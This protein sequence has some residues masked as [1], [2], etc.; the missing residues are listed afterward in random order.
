[1]DNLPE[2]PKAIGNYTTI[3][4]IGYLIYTSGHIPITDTKKFIGKIPNEISIEE[5]YEAASLCAQLTI[6]TLTSSNIELNKITPINIVG[7]VNSEEN[8]KEHA[9]VLNGFTDEFAKYFK[10]KSTRSAVGVTSLP[11]GVCVEV[12]CIFHHE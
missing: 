9:N 6:S 5:G 4:Q 10:D 1:M 7:F 11:L 3:K 8:F 12:Q 2:A